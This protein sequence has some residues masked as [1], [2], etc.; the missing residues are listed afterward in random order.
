[1]NELDSLIRKS[2]KELENAE[3]LIQ[4]DSFNAAVSRTYYAMFYAVQDLFCR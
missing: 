2:L 4:H 3:L 1:M